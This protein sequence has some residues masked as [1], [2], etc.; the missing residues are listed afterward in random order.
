M[1]QIR[2]SILQAKLHVGDHIDILQQALLRFR[3]QCLVIC[4]I[5][6]LRFMFLGRCEDWLAQEHE[7]VN[8]A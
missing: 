4:G 8:D 1:I 7:K 3:N 6:Q 5:T 2:E